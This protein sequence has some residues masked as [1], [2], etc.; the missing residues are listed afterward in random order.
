MSKFVD[1]PLIKKDT[2]ETRIY[3]QLL[4]TKAVKSNSLIVLPTGLGKTVIFIM[5]IAHFIKKF[6]DKSVIISAP[7]RPLVDQHFESLTKFLN[8]DH[9]KIQIISGS[10]LPIIRKNIWQE[11]QVF[12]TTPQTLRNDII[13][14]KV[15]LHKFSLICFDEAHR[16]IGEDPYVLCAQEFHKINKSGRILGF[17]ASPGN[18]K[19]IF[20]LMKN[21]YLNDFEF[22][23]E[24]HPQVKPY[25]HN[26]NEEFVWINLPETYKT[27]LTILETEVKSHL[28]YLKQIGVIKSIVL[29]K[30]SKKQLIQIPKK[31]NQIKNEIEEKDYF[32]TL[33]RY[34]QLMLL[35]QAMEMIETQGAHTLSKYIDDKHIEFQ[36]TKKNSLKR[37]INNSS[38]IKIQKLTDEL[39]NSNTLHPKISTLTNIVNKQLDTKPDSKIIIFSNY[40]ATTSFIVDKLTNIEKI[41][42]HRFVGQSSSSYGKGLTQKEQKSIM[43]DFKTGKFNVLVSTSVG[44][45]GLDVAQCDMVIFYDVTP[46]ATRLIQR[47]GRTGRKRTGKII[48]LITKNTKEEGYFYASQ[49]QKKSIKSSIKDIKSAIEEH[50]EN[51]NQTNLDSFI[52]PPSTIDDEKKILEIYVDHRERGTSIIRKLLEKNVDLKQATLP[53]GDFILSN[54][55][56]I[57]RKTTNDFSQTLIRGDLFPQLIK[58]K[59]TYAKPLLLI[60]GENIFNSS[61]SS[62]AIFGAISSIIVDYNV[63]I[64]YT[65]NEEET[66]SLIL[67]IAKREQFERKSKPTIKSSKSTQSLYEDQIY[68]ISSI[69]N[70]NRTLAERILEYFKTP[71]Q[72]FNAN[73]EDLLKIQGI[74]KLTAQKILD[75]LSSKTE[76]NI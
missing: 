26:T 34:G 56:A 8:I 15:E 50:K 18:Q 66:L 39:L 48:I 33:G 74:G 27:I 62:N 65:S 25:T 55:V 5:A 32:E 45:E 63:P 13:D 52:D 14:K 29:S 72:F 68:L 54:D 20:E 60:E 10:T 36:K 76:K 4:F 31:L 9:N 58:L 51:Q 73:L 46:S 21:L 61:I 3:Q 44:E 23:D 43:N 12:I 75:L 42:P 49:R 41:K 53:V 64:L 28:K 1:H 24:D 47:S 16:A 22:M 2:M 37:F 59:E 7:T 11:A 19:K 57:E 6:P 38:I 40:K 67:T 35:Y 69:P 30:N 71:N 17:T 70:I